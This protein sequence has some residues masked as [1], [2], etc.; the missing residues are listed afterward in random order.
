MRNKNSATVLDVKLYE[1]SS[2]G[3]DRGFSFFH[4]LELPNS[5]QCCFTIKHSHTYLFMRQKIL[6]GLVVQS[7]NRTT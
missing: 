1:I 6:A 3:T 5:K 7:S 4:R 2:H